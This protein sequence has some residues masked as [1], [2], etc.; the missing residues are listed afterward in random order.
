M[1]IDVSS[2]STDKRIRNR[3]K[4]LI[5]LMFRRAGG[6]CGQVPYKNASPSR[7]DRNGRVTLNL[8]NIPYLLLLP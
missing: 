5:G 8:T 1:S 3:I 4:A 6:V 2:T 7:R